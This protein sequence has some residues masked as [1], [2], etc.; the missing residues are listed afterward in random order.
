[1]IDVPIYSV[2]GYTGVYVDVA[3][4]SSYLIHLLSPFLLAEAVRKLRTEGKDVDIFRL[5]FYF[6]GLQL[7][8]DVNVFQNQ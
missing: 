3:I 8:C 5:K 2:A 6:G 1:M 4:S 7:F